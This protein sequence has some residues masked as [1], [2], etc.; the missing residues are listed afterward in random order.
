[1]LQRPRRSGAPR[2]IHGFLG[3]SVVCPAA[4][5]HQAAAAHQPVVTCNRCD[6]EAVVLKLE[7]LF[8][9]A[10]CLLLPFG[11]YLGLA[12]APPE[13]AM[14]DVYRI[15]YVHVPCAWT[16]LAGFTVT[17]CCSV[18]YLFYKPSWKLDALAVATA[19]VGLFMS[20][21]LLIT[22]SLWGKPTWG[23]WW[24]WD[25]R[26]TTMFILALAFGGYL[27]LRHFVQT[28]EKR[29]TWSAVAA[30][31]ISA[32]VPIVWLTVH[33]W[34]TLHQVLSF[35]HTMAP[36]MTVALAVNTIGFACVFLFLTHV[37]YRIGRLR[38]KIEVIPPPDVEQD[39]AT[40]V[41]A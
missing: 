8:L 41:P 14:G 11:A 39:A 1:M 21:M 18:A 3:I 13:I 9:G 6:T 20:A 27:L 10:A 24:T 36:E 28:P 26:L 37:R 30:I 25:P 5:Q 16:A 4:S 23:A 22:G 12:W 33:W 38:Q 17:F 32:D 35:P 34:N 19:E 40:G 31:V 29:A 15:I 2:Q 7:R